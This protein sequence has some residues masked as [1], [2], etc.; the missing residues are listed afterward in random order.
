MIENTI[1]SNSVI[2]NMFNV[3]SLAVGTHVDAQCKILYHSLALAC[4]YTSCEVLNS[5]FHLRKVTWRILVDF[6]FCSPPKEK[7]KWVEVRAV[8]SPL[9]AL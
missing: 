5:L 2:I 6:T 8:R 9:N 3:T 1:L 7:I 4:W